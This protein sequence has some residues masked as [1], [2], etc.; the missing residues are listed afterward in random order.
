M[1]IF[2]GGRKWYKNSEQKVISKTNYLPVNRGFTIINSKHDSYFFLPVYVRKKSTS[3]SP[4][5]R[6]TKKENWIHSTRTIPIFYEFILFVF[7]WYNSAGIQENITLR[8][9][10]LLFHFF[11]SGGDFLLNALSVS[12]GFS[13]LPNL[14][15]DYRTDFVIVSFEMT[16][17]LFYRG[18]LDYFY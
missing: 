2:P 11:F 4:V 5:M 17:E 8:N 10:K 12:I 18:L 13:E 14:C 7:D 1:A 6:K 3:F 16:W 15:E 9:C